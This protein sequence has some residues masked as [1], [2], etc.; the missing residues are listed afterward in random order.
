MIKDLIKLIRSVYGDGEIKLHATKITEDDIK[1]VTEAMKK[2]VDCYGHHVKDFENG[3]AEYTRSKHVIA[4]CSG[5]AA[6][7]AILNHFDDKDYAWLPNYTF[8]GTL[9]AAVKAGF[10]CY[11]SD[12][13][14]STLGMDSFW[15]E[16]VVNIP[17]YLFGMP[18]DMELKAGLIIEDAC[19][20]L[21]TF[22]EGKHAGT[23]GEAGALSFNGN[24]IIT[25]G[26]GG[27]ILT[28]NNDLA[29]EIREFIAK[30]FN[31]RMPALNAALGLSQL[32]RIE[33][34]ISIKREIAHRYQELFEGTEVKFLKEP[35]NTRAN[36]WLSTIILPNSNIRDSWFDT[37]VEKGI[38]CRKGF[39]VLNKDAD[40]PVVN[41][42]ADRVLSLPSGVPL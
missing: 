39:E 40:T 29:E 38:E 7:Y 11:Y 25:T 21:G 42:Y 4:T 2:R 30:D 6:L 31:L 34:I 22:F 10:D 28:D 1:F 27:A 8:E 12:V 32:M 37:L 13:N 17:V 26:G 36:Y 9:N 19:Q 3:L 15:V 5:T 24:K 35:K 18:Y 20:A 23:F 41:E 16:K 14:T 33:D